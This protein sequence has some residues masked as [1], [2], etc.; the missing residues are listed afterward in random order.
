MTVTKAKPEIPKEEETSEENGVQGGMLNWISHGFANALPQPAGTLRLSRANS[1]AKGCTWSATRLRQGG[2]VIGW[3]VQGLGKVVP[4]PDD[5]YKDGSEPD[6]EIHYAKDVPDA[7]PLSNKPVVEVQSED[8]VFKLHASTQPFSPSMIDWIKNGFEKMVPQPEIQA[9]LPSEPPSK[10]D[11]SAPVKVTF[12]PIESPEEETNGS[13]MM[14]WI[15]KGLG[16]MMPQL[17]LK[18]K[19][20][21]GEGAE[22]VQNIC[23]CQEPVDMV[24]EDMDSD[25]ENENQQQALNFQLGMLSQVLAEQQEDAEMQT[26]QYTPSMEPAGDSQEQLESRSCAVELAG[27]AEESVQYEEDQGEILSTEATHKASNREQL[28]N[29][30]EEENKD[31]SECLDNMYPVE[32]TLSPTQLVSDAEEEKDPSTE[33]KE[34]EVPRQGSQHEAKQQLPEPM[35]THPQT[36]EPEP[37]EAMESDSLTP[38]VDKPVTQQ[39]EPTKDGHPLSATA[40]EDETAEEGCGMP[41]SCIAVRNWLMCMPHTSACLA[42][43]NQLLQE[44]N[45]TL[46]KLPT[47]PLLPLIT[48]QIH[49]LPPQLSQLPQRA[50]QYYLNILNRLNS[51]KPQQDA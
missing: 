2:G 12:P 28:P 31:V 4:H 29:I 34:P 17:V 8:D 37:D 19:E 21:T 43:F 46:P 7:D 41:T 42:H 6:D 23:I 16:H 15:V 22:V 1:E 51:L 35:K 3:I 45:M 40:Q 13:N 47:K 38:P 26:E 49:R 14:G 27:R 48:Q 11:V 25:W 10:K 24:V 33:A 39:P 18:P 32:G 36:K 20:D 5:K 9:P 44:N 30:Q 50:Q